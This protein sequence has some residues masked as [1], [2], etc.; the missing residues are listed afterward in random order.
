MRRAK[1]AV[2][3]GHVGRG[4]QILMQED[5]DYPAGVQSQAIFEK[6]KALHPPAEREPLP[7][8]DVHSQTLIVQPADILKCAKAMAKGE[9]PGP[10]GL[11]SDVLW[12]ALEEEQ[13]QKHCVLLDRVTEAVH[14]ILTNETSAATKAAVTAIRLVAV[15]KRKGGVRPVAMSEV[16]LKLA[17]RI[18]LEQCAGLGSEWKHQFGLRKGGAEMAVHEVRKHLREGKTVYALDA[19]NA[20]NAVHRSAFFRRL[21]TLESTEKVRIDLLKAYANYTYGSP[22]WAYWENDEG[23][24]QRIPVMRGVRQGD[25]AS[26]LLFCIAMQPILE[27][28]A[29]ETGVEVIAYLDDVTLCGEADQV[30]RASRLVAQYCSAIGLEIGVEQSSSDEVA[31]KVGGLRILGAAICTNPEDTAKL[32]EAIHPLRDYDRFIDVLDEHFDGPMRLRLLRQC[33]VSK[34]G[35]AARCHGDEATTY[36]EGF[37]KLSYRCLSHIVGVDEE[38][39]MT[40]R[41]AFTSMRMG[42]IGITQWAKIAKVCYIAST[43]GE[44]QDLL[45]DAVY[46]H[47]HGATAVSERER[48]MRGWVEGDV[49][50]P[51]RAYPAMLRHVLGIAEPGTLVFAGE[52]I[53]CPAC[54]KQQKDVV[55]FVHEHAPQCVLYPGPGN[56][57]ERHNSVTVALQRRLTAYGLSVNREVVVDRHLRLSPTPGVPPKERIM[58]LIVNNGLWIDVTITNDAKRQIADKHRKYAALAQKASITLMAIAFSPEGM[59]C[60]ESWPHASRLAKMC[61]V[62]VPQLFGESAAIIASDSAAARVKA[63]EHVVALSDADALLSSCP[64]TLPST[65]GLEVTELTPG[66]SVLR[67]PLSCQSADAALAYTVQ[68]PSAS[69]EQVAARRT[70]GAGAT[71]QPVDDLGGDGPAVAGTHSDDDGAFSGHADGTIDGDVGE[72]DEGAGAS[73]GLDANQHPAEVNGHRASPSTPSAP[74]HHTTHQ[75]KAPARPVD[76]ATA[77]TPNTSAGVNPRPGQPAGATPAAATCSVAPRPAADA[78]A[79]TRAPAHQTT[80]QAQARETATPVS[81]AQARTVGQAEAAVA[82]EAAH[83]EL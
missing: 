40:S 25:P 43:R 14:K 19:T 38:T 83:T 42:G 8:L 50:S 39:L 59:I 49:E 46:E 31:T 30:E 80:A 78:D 54:H 66:C 74:S 22:S 27:R 75:A 73:S 15:P 26:P 29:R 82:G 53:K 28:V 56:P 35:Y 7:H 18:A 34:A 17:A 51:P 71:P 11:A 81:A 10:S 48:S 41:N 9:A 58:D 76:R 62:S 47:Q 23:E 55:H 65:D 72:P 45:V 64:D 77:A 79:V 63:A 52:P 2:M 32:L 67:A 21:A 61:E 16:I 13:R 1:A 12:Q 20:Y 5:V 24:V 60:T 4:V 37:D 68:N 3:A 57:T 44:R 70:R 6:L 36:L 69:A 33:G